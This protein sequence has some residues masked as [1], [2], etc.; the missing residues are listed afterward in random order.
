MGQED[1]YTRTH[2]MEL[3]TPKHFRPQLIATSHGTE[4]TDRQS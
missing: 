1:I 4:D 2:A 3:P